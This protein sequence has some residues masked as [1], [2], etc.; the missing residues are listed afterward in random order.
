VPSI[1]K[2]RMVSS[3]TEATLAALRLARGYTL[4]FSIEGTLS[5]TSS[6]NLFSSSVEAPKLV[7]LST[8]SG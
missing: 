7:P 6:A 4:T 2:V 3:G 1:E 8:A 5:I